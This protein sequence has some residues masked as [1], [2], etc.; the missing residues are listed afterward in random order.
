MISDLERITI[1]AYVDSGDT[2]HVVLCDEY[3]AQAQRTVRRLLQCGLDPG[4]LLYPSMPE[5]ERR[6]ICA[7]VARLR[8]YAK[9]GQ[10]HLILPPESTA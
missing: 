9:L 7:I 8:H 6:Q 1:M 2:P 5:R 4:D 10:I 3:F